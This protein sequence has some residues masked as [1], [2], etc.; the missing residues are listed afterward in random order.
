ML[1]YFISSHN[2]GGQHSQVL[3]QSDCQKIAHVS[4]VDVSG[5]SF[6]CNSV[7]KPSHGY[8]GLFYREQEFVVIVMEGQGEA[9]ALIS[10]IFAT[11]VAGVY[12]SYLDVQIM[13]GVGFSPCALP[14]VKPSA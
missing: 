10:Y 5:D 9:I 1:R 14:L 8:D 11:G 2:K 13:E 4:D 6:F 12:N 7:W 3:G